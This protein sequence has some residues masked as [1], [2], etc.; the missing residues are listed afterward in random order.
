MGIN[1]PASTGSPEQTARTTSMTAPPH[2]ATMEDPAEM[3]S[4]PSSVIVLLDSPAADV[5]S[6]TMTVSTISVRTESAWTASTTS[7]ATATLA[8]L[9]DSATPRLTSVRSTHVRME[10][11]VKN[12]DMENTR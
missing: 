1:A 7:P 4:A 9:G 2:P 5:R 12:Y 8:S 10:A 11:L 3:A 6:T